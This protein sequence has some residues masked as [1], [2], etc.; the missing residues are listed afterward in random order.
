MISPK[1][2]IFDWAGTLVDFGCRAPLTAFHAAF[3]AVG[4]PIS[5]EVARRPMGAHKRDHVRE[6]L[7]DPAIADRV[8]AVLHTE[9]DDPL[10]ERIYGEFSR[11]LPESLPL[12]AAPI[13]GS[14]E[15]LSWLRG[16]GIRIGS[17]TGYTRSMMDLLEPIA[18]AA[19]IAPE[20]VV[21]ADEVPQARPAPWACFRIADQLGIQPLSEAI[22][23]GDTPADMA[24]GRNAGM[25]CIGLSECG[26]EVGLGRDDLE[27]L[28]AGE[29]AARV[30]AAELRLYD[31]GAHAVLRSVADLPAWIEAQRP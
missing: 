17:T 2:V 16:R 8:R 4:L 27:A 7:H 20:I 15:A 5:D 9:P 31:A 22:K 12:H 14:V 11:V 1:L 19:G 29:R 24:E 13:P 28:P 6:I 23:V 18:R 10:V 21:C 26:N 30:A 25:V 3:R